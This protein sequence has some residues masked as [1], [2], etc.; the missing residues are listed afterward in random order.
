MEQQNREPRSTVQQQL[1]RELKDSIN[2]KEKQTGTYHHQ[3]TGAHHE[4]PTHVIREDSG[5]LGEGERAQLV[6]HRVGTLVSPDPGATKHLLKMILSVLK[7]LSSGDS[8]AEAN[9]LVETLAEHSHDQIQDVSTRDLGKLM[10][11]DEKE[12]NRGRD[13]NEGKKG[14]E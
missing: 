14:K 2:N 9:P 3:R 8:I 5:P 11:E 7:L 13:R 10:K 6:S 12:Q 4:T 1:G